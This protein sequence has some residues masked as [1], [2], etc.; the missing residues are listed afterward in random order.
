MNPIIQAIIT[1]ALALLNSTAQPT[2]VPHLYCTVDPLLGAVLLGEPEC[3]Y[4]TEPTKQANNDTV[5]SDTPVVV[6][7]PAIVVTVE[8]TEITPPAPIIEITPP[9][10][11]VE[12]SCNGGNPAIRSV[13]VMQAKTRTAKVLWTMTPTDGNGEH[14]NQGKNKNK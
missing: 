2:Q 5:S 13:R 1:A 7:T 8:E 11:V 14:G 12:E 9:A 6:S 4:G 3:Y 10:P